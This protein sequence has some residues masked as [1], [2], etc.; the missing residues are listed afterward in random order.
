MLS[1]KACTVQVRQHLCLKMLLAAFQRT[2]QWLTYP[3]QAPATLGWA[4]EL[5]LFHNLQQTCSMFA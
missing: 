2:G 1:C 4:F 5:A 3:R